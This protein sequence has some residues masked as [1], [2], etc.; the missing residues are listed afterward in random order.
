M[1]TEEA[2]LVYSILIRTLKDYVITLSFFSTAEIDSTFYEKFYSH[3][4]KGT[5][6]GTTRA[7]PEANFEDA[8]KICM[9]KTSYSQ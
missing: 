1:P 6:I 3:M 4:T 9:I 7:T 8:L 2:G 5:F